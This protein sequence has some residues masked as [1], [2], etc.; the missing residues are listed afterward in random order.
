MAKQQ[1]D[2]EADIKSHLEEQTLSE[3]PE[4][5][6]TVM[7]CCNFD[8]NLQLSQGSLVVIEVRN[9]IWNQ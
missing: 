2:E 3:V 6:K 1:F 7:V 9:V 8:S 5:E 4:S